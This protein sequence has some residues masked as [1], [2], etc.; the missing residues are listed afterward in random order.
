M[1]ENCC[2]LIA[3]KKL[4]FEALSLIRDNQ[5][6]QP[7]VPVVPF[8]YD[9]TKDGWRLLTEGSLCPETFIP[10]VRK[11]MLPGEFCLNGEFMMRRAGSFNALGQHC[12]EY[13]LERLRLIPVE[14]QSHDLV[15]PETVW[16]N[17]DGCSMMVP[18][19]FYQGIE[20]YLTFSWVG[21]T[22]L[23]DVQ[24]VVSG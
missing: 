12:A 1:T 5:E 15:F 18:C 21:N 2:G 4:S 8:K 3:S 9:K 6:T 17:N 10:K 11:F 16:L 14:E 20:R 22:W 23:P 13:L 7:V 19:L 24:F